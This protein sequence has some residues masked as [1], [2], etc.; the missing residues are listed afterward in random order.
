MKM[1]VFRSCAVCLCLLGCAMAV[2]YDMEINLSTGVVTGSDSSISWFTTLVGSSNIPC[3]KRGVLKLTFNSAG[4]AKRKVRIDMTFSNPKGYSF[5]IGDSR[6]N[7]AWGGDSRTQSRDAEI[8]SYNKGMHVYSNDYNSPKA[9]KYVTS[10]YKTSLQFIITDGIVTWNN[11]EGYFNSII[12]NDLFAL[13]GQSDTEGSVNY[14]IYLA[15]NR[16]I[17]GGRRGSGLCSVGI[18]WLEGFS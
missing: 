17:Y 16:V 7:N 11:G 13:K 18:K 15:M 6:T 4:L 9:H 1:D 12:K 3:S 2:T 8:H 5:N 10:T 14:D